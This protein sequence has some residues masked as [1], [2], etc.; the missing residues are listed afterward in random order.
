MAAKKDD[1]VEAV[2]ETVEKKIEMTPEEI[3]AMIQKA[4]DEALAEYRF[5]YDKSGDP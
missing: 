1:T 4:K 3:K 2:K 5:H